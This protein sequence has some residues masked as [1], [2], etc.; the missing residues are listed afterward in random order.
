MLAPNPIQQPCPAR[1]GTPLARR[2]AALPERGTCPAPQKRR[3]FSFYTVS[4]A[5]KAAA[6][7]KRDAASAAERGASGA[8]DASRALE[9]VSLFLRDTSRAR[10]AGAADADSQ[11]FTHISTV[12]TIHHPCKHFVGTPPTPPPASPLSGATPPPSSNRATPATPR[13]FPPT[14]TR[15]KYRV[16]DAQAGVW[17]ANWQR[18]GLALTGNGLLRARGWTT[19]GYLNGGSGLIEQVTGFTFYTPLQQWKLTHL[20]DVA[21]PNDGDTHFDGLRT[22]LEYATGGDPLVPGALPA[23]GTAAGKLTLTFPRN[24]AATDVTLTVQGSDDLTT[25]TDLARSSAG[26]PM[27]A[28]VAGVNATETGAGALRTVEVRD[29][30]FLINDPA[31]PRR[32]LRLHAAP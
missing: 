22:I 20:G 4:P 17:S 14:L 3:P 8:R 19:N 30:L 21:A 6:F 10:E 9:A 32:F 7:G 31:H 24:T 12:F 5:V 2:N 1:Q 25:W 11:G 26:A 23:A 28:L 29:L 18:T 13:H 16:A 27:V 15:W